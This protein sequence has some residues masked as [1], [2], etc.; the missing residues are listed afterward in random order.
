LWEI[1]IFGKRPIITW[2]YQKYKRLY[3]SRNRATLGRI[4]HIFPPYD[5]KLTTFHNN[6]PFQ[7]YLIFRLPVL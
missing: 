2:S 7:L 1:L 4:V 6:F 5:E 3:K